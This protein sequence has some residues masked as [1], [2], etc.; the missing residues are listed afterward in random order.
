MTKYRDSGS[1]RIKRRRFTLTALIISKIATN[2]VQD[3][4]KEAFDIGLEVNRN[5]TDIV[6]LTGPGE[7]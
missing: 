1:S 3:Q 6:T 7:D 5:V 2:Q 4:G